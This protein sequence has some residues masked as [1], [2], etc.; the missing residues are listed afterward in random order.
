MFKGS[1]MTMT[2]SSFVFCGGQ[3]R[4]ELRS[5]SYELRS[6]SSFILAAG[7]TSKFNLRNSKFIYLIHDAK[8]RRIIDANTSYDTLRCT[9]DTL[10]I[11]LRAVTCN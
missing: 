9:Y 8:L 6:T 7:E 5:W 11:H 1:T 3:E 2:F 10:M 4:I